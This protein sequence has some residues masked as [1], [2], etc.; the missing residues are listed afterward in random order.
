MTQSQTNDPD[1]AGT[2]WVSATATRNFLLG[3]P[4][5]DW[6]ELYGLD[7]GFTSDDKQPNYDER[8]EFTPFITE[9]SNAFE[10]AIADH[11]RTLTEVVDI[12]RG[13]PPI[14]DP[15]SAKATLDAMRAGAPVIYQGVLHDMGTQTYGSPDFLLRS[16]TLVELFPGSL[17]PDALVAGA[18]ALEARYH[19]VVVDVKFTTLKLL[20]SG[21][22]GDSE[23]MQAYKGQLFVYNRA[24]GTM[25][26]YTPETAYLLGRGWEQG[27]E[28]K[29]NAFDRLGPA[30]MDASLA[31]KTN[32][33]VDWVRRVRGEGRDWEVLP[34]PTV[35][36]LFPNATA[37]GDFPWH[38][39]KSTIAKG[40]DEL[41]QLW[42]VGV[43]KRAAAVRSGVTRW[44]DPKVSA[45]MLGVTGSTTQPKLQ[46][47][48]DLHHDVDRPLV[49][50]AIVTAAQREWRPVPPL[51]FFVDFETVSNLNDDMD[52]IPE[53]HGQSL[54]YMIGCGH[55]ARGEW[56]FR[57]FTTDTLT[58][59]SEAEVIDSWIAHM[60]ETTK[61]IG[62][63]QSAKIFHWSA[64]EISFYQT[65]YDS[66]C[67][68]QPAKGWPELEWFDL[69]DRVF[70]AEPVVVRGALGFGLKTIAK[71]MFGHELIA[72]S[73][74][75]SKVDGLGAMTGAW[76]CYS[77]SRKQGVSMRDF[78]LMKEIEAYNEVDCKVMMELLT[79][80]RTNH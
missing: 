26:D 55:A 41:T 42:Q 16:D 8:L 40:L 7:H 44:T 18:P 56:V 13:T 38:T 79:Y 62:A 2:D 12:A 47:I 17:E 78:A 60:D 65:A 31:M 28:R 61:A 67:R 53:P 34:E 10:A 1:D 70:R 68:R 4:L 66:A 9:R 75:E 27:R 74:G 45:Q 36:E 25:Q 24:L 32:A 54:I 58:E 46:A 15:Q 20:V 39:V 21:Q 59:T 57:Q 51:E 48:I 43:D 33:A 3:D 73:W 29:A 35:P 72:T 77:E 76:W 30:V 49:R 64:A 22:V 37:D 14:H 23:G 50:P 19:Y 63:G 71:A 11:F 5:V 52:L 80:L 69:L 6:L